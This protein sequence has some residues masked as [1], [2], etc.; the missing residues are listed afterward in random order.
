M[1]NSR[2]SDS[3]AQ[4][5]RVL[6]VDLDG[7]LIRSD[8]LWEC[9]VR[10]LRRPT[11]LIGSLVWLVD[12]KARFKKYM[13]D[14]IGGE[15]SVAHLPYNQAVLDLIARR[16]EEG[17]RVELVSA[18]HE[19]LVDRVADHLGLF[20]AAFGSDGTRNLS[21]SQK[22]TFMAARHPDGYAYIGNSHA[23]L[24]AWKDAEEAI[25]ADAPRA[26][27]DRVRGDGVEIAEVSRSPFVLANLIS[28]MRL[29][30]WAKNL[31]L[32]VPFILEFQDQG[33]P[34]LGLIL[35]AFLAFGLMA[36]A[37]YIFNDLLDLDADRRHE[38][39]RQRPFAAGQVPIPIGLALMTMLLLAGFGMGFTIGPAFTAYLI[40]YTALTLLYSLQLKSLPVLDV[41][42]LGLLFC[43]R[44]IAGAA[45]IDA[46]VTA[47][48][49]TFSLLFF[50]S[51]ALAKRYVEMARM[52]TLT[53]GFNN[54]ETIA[55]R[56]Y[57]VEDR[58]FAF[59]FGAALA[60]ASL[61]VFL[62]YAFSGETQAFFNVEVA[63]FCLGALAYWVMRIWLLTL[64]GEMNE[65]PVLFAVKDRLSYITGATILLALAIDRVLR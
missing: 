19:T 50:T 64:R 46:E 47:W 3:V 36:S 9:S 30:Q 22:A 23:D 48:L 16:R 41:L 43:I 24:A 32:F 10:A 28:A 17:W 63:I 34:E 54:G 38:T 56:G 40:A 2:A 31:L 65:D 55:G 44:I 15:I 51:L 13:A 62:L 12:G 4:P 39:K 33:W 57:T 7:T 45:A 52:A 8:L 29:H 11:L 59:G 14:G 42:V 25:A 20:D 37:T 1:G 61:L 27:L 49:A 58:I 35:L 60:S 53:G 21:G 18:S 5:V 26:L 6:C